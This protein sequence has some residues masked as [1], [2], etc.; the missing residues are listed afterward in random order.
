MMCLHN[1]TCV[2]L[3]L[4]KTLPV[5]QS[6]LDALLNFDVGI[7]CLLLVQQIYQVFLVMCIICVNSIYR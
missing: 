2:W 4:L 5:L 6:H 7:F 1:M 3:Q